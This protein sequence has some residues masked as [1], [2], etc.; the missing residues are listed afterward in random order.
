M[1]N[2]LHKTKCQERLNFIHDNC[3]IHKTRLRRARFAKKV[4]QKHEIDFLSKGLDLDVIEHLWRLMDQ[5]WDRDT[6]RTKQNILN[7]LMERWEEFRGGQV[8]ENMLN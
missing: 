6:T 7:R 8:C 3:A 1:Y 5:T 2:R 4:L